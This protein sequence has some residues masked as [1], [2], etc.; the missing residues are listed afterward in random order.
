MKSALHPFIDSIKHLNIVRNLPKYFDPQERRLVFQ[1]IVIGVVVWAVVYALKIAVHDV[2][3]RVLHWL[4]HGP[5]EAL[6]FVPLVVGALL[7]ALIARMG[8]SVV[9]YRDKDGQLHELN[10]VEG[11]GLERAI[12]MY[13]ASEPALEQSLLGKEGVDV[14]WQMP[15]FTLALR[16]F[17]AT[18]ITLGS[19]GSGGLEASVALIGESVSAGLFKPR[20]VVAAA[21]KRVGLVGR[22]WQWWRST[23]PDDLQTAQLGGIAAAVATLLGAPF[24]AAFFAIEVMYQRRP[25]IE[26]LIYALISALIAYFLSSVFSGGHTAIFEVEHLA[27][28]PATFQYFAVSVLVAALVSLVSIYF[29]RMHNSFEKWFHEMKV[30]SWQRHLAGAIVTG[31]IALLVVIVAREWLG[32]E[33]GLTLVLGSGE[34]AIHAALAGELTTAIALVALFAKLLATLATIASGGSAGLLVPSIFFGTMVAAAVAPLFELPAVTLII[35][36]MAASLVSIVNV[37]LAAT[38]FTVEVF[39]APYMLPALVTLVVTSILAHE[40]SIYRTQRAKFDSRQILPGFGVRRVPISSEWDGKT[41][42]DLRIRNRFGLNVIG[43]MEHQSADGQ[44]MPHVQLSPDVAAPLKA[45]DILVVLG[46]DEALDA[47]EKAA[48]QHTV[49]R[50]EGAE[51]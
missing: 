18:L 40:N 12:S 47:F 33:H 50:D 30:A 19:G 43:I 42:I 38:L 13:Y 29:Q 51:G 27:D 41:I 20:K 17:L 31:T 16:K 2:F 9:H 14:R 7:V 15:T 46:E 49:L 36:A 23:E 28:P 26:K 8:A 6:L 34:E 48:Q 32:Y 21:D 45:N 22:F 10:D 4:E 3:G 5:S 25:I 44:F 35:P 11:D 39:G 37:P 1:S 24:A